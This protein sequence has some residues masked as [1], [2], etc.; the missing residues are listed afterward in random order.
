MGTIYA[1][2]FVTIVICLGI[3]FWSVR[4][5]ELRAARWSLTNTGAASSG[6]AQKQVFVKSVLYI[7]T[8]LVIWIPVFISLPTNHPNDHYVLTF[9]YPLQGLLNA[10]IYSDLPWRTIKG[11]VTSLVRSIKTLIPLCASCWISSPRRES[12][13][14]LSHAKLDDSNDGENIVVH[15]ETDNFNHDGNNKTE[16]NGRHNNVAAP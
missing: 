5:Q 13:S 2:V 16:N 12:S 10:L 8:F 6:R 4:T 11:C 7:G 3:V 9:F 14:G 1:L 15:R